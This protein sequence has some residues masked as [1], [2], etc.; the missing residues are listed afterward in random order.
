MLRLARLDA[1]GVLHHII[2]RGIERRDIFINDADRDD[3][4]GRLAKLIPVTG[5]ACYAWAFLGNHAHFLFRT[6]NVP[7][8]T[9]MRRLITGYAVGFNRRHQRIGHLFQN[10]YKSIVCQEEVYLKEL[11]RYIHLYPLRAGIVS[12]VS[13][14][15]KYP[16]CG[17]SAIIGK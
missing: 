5:T 11:L 16:Y 9:L 14:L 3:M 15:A 13:Q 17:H 6:G 4:I 7:L 1:P 10:R 12:N 8:S 2:I